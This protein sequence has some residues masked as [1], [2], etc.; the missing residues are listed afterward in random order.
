MRI[1]GSVIINNR[2]VSVYYQVLN[3][4][5]SYHFSKQKSG[6]Y[7]VVLG[8]YEN[9]YDPSTSPNKKSKNVTATSIYK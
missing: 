4:I 6:G 8:E 2:L 7:H 9:Q 5:L 3:R 1:T